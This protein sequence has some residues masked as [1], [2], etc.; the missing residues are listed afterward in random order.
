MPKPFFLRE[1]LSIASGALF[2]IGSNSTD[3]WSGPAYD[4]ASGLDRN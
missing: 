4:A 3:G 1:W 2:G